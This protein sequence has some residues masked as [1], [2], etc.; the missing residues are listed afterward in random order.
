MGEIDY[1]DIAKTIVKTS[2][3]VRPKEKVVI[4]GREDTLHLCE[5]IGIECCKIG[6]FPFI[7]V[8]SDGYLLHRLLD[9][10]LD[11]LKQT[12]LHELSLVQN[13]DV[14]IVT[15]LQPED[16]S[17]LDRVCEER[18][19]A[20]KLGF[21][22]IAQMISP[23]FGKRWLFMDC[24]TA[25][26][27]RVYGVDFK[28]YFRTFWRAVRVDHQKTYELAQRLRKTLREAKTVTITSAR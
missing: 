19:S 10:P 26:Q 13:S 5:L 27:A 6:A 18:V 1:S 24:P 23:K 22:Q 16:P 17:I 2:L 7:S 14:I 12:P 11:S 28:K 25:E 4:Y 15:H 3:R 20:E 8:R 9:T 21:K